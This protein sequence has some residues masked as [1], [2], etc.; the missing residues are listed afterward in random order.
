M[1]QFHS[2]QYFTEGYDL[3]AYYAYDNPVPVSGIIHVGFIQ[4]NVDRLNIGLD[5]NSNANAGNLHYKLSPGSNWLASEIPGSVMIHPVLRAGIELSI[6]E[7]ETFS[8]GEISSELYPNPTSSEVSFK[9]YEDM[10]WS[11]YSLSGRE[12][13]RGESNPS[14]TV[15][16]DTSDL[17]AGVYWVGMTTTSTSV[18]SGKKLIILPQ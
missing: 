16:I 2:P 11:V 6:D 10:V 3:F 4:Q 13:M 12:L 1:Y 8:T 17:P 7:M 14:M 5:K 18:S 15:T 9:T